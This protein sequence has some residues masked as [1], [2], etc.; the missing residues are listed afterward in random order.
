MGSVHGTHRDSIRTATRTPLPA[1]AG[2]GASGTLAAVHQLNRAGAPLRPRVVLID[3]DGRHG[4]GVAY[5]TPDPA[6]LLNT[7]AAAMSAYSG[8]P[9][10]LVRWA[11][12][13]GRATGG[14]DLL[15]RYDYGDYLRDTLAAQEL[16]HGGLE[17][18]TDRVTGIAL[19]PY[20]RPVL[21]CATLGPLT[22]DIAIVATGHL[23][24][25]GD[26]TADPDLAGTLIA[27]GIARPEPL[28]LGL[29]T[30]DGALLTPYGHPHDR[31]F[32]LGPPRRGALDDST[33]VPKIRAKAERLAE[34]IT[35][36]LDRP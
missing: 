13:L 19:G 3:D 36:L 14:G 18:R 9:H 15:T 25:A 33:A 22:A 20:G 12:D 16:L 5:A 23:P 30:R 7:P 32:T 26:V 11:T 8:D 21:R 17:L 34:R 1:I 2:G 29:E 10:H 31:L 27:D 6:H 35:T 4:R 28:R 24:S